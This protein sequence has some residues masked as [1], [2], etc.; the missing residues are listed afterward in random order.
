MNP[1]IGSPFSNSS[2]EET[3]VA[4]RMWGAD[5][6]L[7]AKP[8]NTQGERPPR[9]A[10]SIAAASRPNAGK[11]L[12]ATQVTTGNPQFPSAQAL[13]TPLSS[14]LLVNSQLTIHNSPAC[15]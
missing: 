11:Q 8:S 12:D 13:R 9:G 3:S 1:I 2:T 14:L 7:R 4:C 6:H 5:W 15:S 10:T